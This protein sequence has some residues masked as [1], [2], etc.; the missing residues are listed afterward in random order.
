MKNMVNMDCNIGVTGFPLRSQEFPV[1]LHS[2]NILVFRKH[3]L[4][5]FFIL[6]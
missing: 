2:L 1:V 6:Y 4:I 5:K 3:Q